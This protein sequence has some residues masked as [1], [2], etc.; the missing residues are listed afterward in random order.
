[1]VISMMTTAIVFDEE[2]KEAIEDAHDDYALEQKYSFSVECR[3][4]KQV[5]ETIWTGLH[6]QGSHVQCCYEVVNSCDVVSVGVSK[7][8]KISCNE[9]LEGLSELFEVKLSVDYGE[10]VRR[11]YNR[12]NEALLVEIGF[13]GCYDEHKSVTPPGYAFA[14]LIDHIETM[15]PT[16]STG[17]TLRLRLK[18]VDGRQLQ[19]TFFR[20]R[21][22]PE[23]FPGNLHMC[24]IT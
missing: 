10:S 17:M 13:F 24:C 3:S 12:R 19:L 16:A 5:V 15:V 18:D 14:I 8:G 11:I 21:P 6:G 4:G 1:M 7:D 2:T 22:K 20:G 9:L 23:R